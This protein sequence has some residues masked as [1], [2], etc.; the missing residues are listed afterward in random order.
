MISV[1]HEAV[2]TQTR[3]CEPEV[4]Q[5]WAGWAE[6]VPEA[7]G[8][9][10]KEEASWVEVEEVVAKEVLLEDHASSVA[11]DHLTT[12]SNPQSMFSWDKLHLHWFMKPFQCFPT[13]CKPI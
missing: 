9:A 4:E 2:C 1:R 12:Q 6:M 8:P 3:V 5:P 11:S 13:L 10:G 7:L